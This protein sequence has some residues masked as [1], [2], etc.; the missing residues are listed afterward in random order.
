MTKYEELQ[1]KIGFEFKNET[2]LNQVFIHRSYLNE[3]RQEGIESNE[4]LEFLGDAVLELISTDYLFKKHPDYSEGEMTNYRSALVK[5]RH[6]ADIAHELDLGKYLHLSRGEDH[7]NGRE[8]NHILANTLEALIGAM[9]LDRGFKQ[10]EKF[11][12]KMILNRLEDIIEK[13]LHIDPKSQFQELIQEKIGVTPNYEILSE[14][15]PDHDK[16]FETGVHVEGMMIATG[17]GSSKQK[18]EEEAAK[19]ALTK[20]YEK[21][22]GIVVFNEEG[23]KRKY[24]VLHYPGGHF[25]FPKGHV[26]KGEESDEHKTALRELEEETGIKDAEL[27]EGFRHKV[28]YTYNKQGKPSFKE[29]VFFLGKTKTEDVKISFEH[30]N[31]MWLE[32]KEAFDKVTFENAK[33][34]LEK[35]EAFLLK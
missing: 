28:H 27:I 22:C 9:Y 16:R 25:D 3:H 21:S 32:Y 18:A 12:K 10:V 24:L 14:S 35:A 7:S 19:A 23:G 6:L 13:K 15:G 4:R 29:V 30:K 2:L 33:N 34:L 17:I 11:A 8:K 5:G 20:M 31:S 1:L 26:E